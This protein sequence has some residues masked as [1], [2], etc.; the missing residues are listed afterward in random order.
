MYF[1]IFAENISDRI[2]NIV[3]HESAT[4]GITIRSVDKLFDK[5]VILCRCD[6]VED[7]SNIVST[8]ETDRDA[9]VMYIEDNLGKNVNFRALPM[10]VVPHYSRYTL[11]L[12]S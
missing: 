11:R 2:F 7:L 12:C 3:E 1:R 4:R 8:L 9:F 6:C 10:P 5:R